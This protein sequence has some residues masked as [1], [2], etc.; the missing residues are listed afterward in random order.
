M[1]KISKIG[2]IL[3]VLSGTALGMLFAPRKGKEL[4]EKI[5]KNLKDGDIK[6]GGQELL[7]DV[8]MMGGEVFDTA[9]DL[10]NSKD[11]QGALKKAKTKAKKIYNENIKNEL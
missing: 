11:V 2:W 10:Y 1:G 4:R 7:K 9:K 8:K 6:S 5:Q 3:G